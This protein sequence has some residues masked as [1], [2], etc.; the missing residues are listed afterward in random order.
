MMLALGGEL[1]RVVGDRIMFD[2]AEYWILRGIFLDIHELQTLNIFRFSEQKAPKDRVPFQFQ[3]V[4]CHE[5]GILIFSP[6]M[7]CS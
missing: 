3:Q 1:A 7:K 2:R 5:L 6:P 4:F